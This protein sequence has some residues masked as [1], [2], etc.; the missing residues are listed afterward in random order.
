M[1]RSAI[2]STIQATG[3]AWHACAQAVCNLVASVTVDMHEINASLS[4][5][6]ANA[7]KSE[8]SFTND[9]A[10]AEQGVQLKRNW[11]K[12][13]SL[14]GVMAAVAT[15]M[16]RHPSPSYALASEPIGQQVTLLLSF[17][18]HMPVNTSAG[19]CKVTPCS[20]SKGQA[21][22]AILCIYYIVAASRA[23]GNSSNVHT[24]RCCVAGVAPEGGTA[25]CCREC[26]GRSMH[27]CMW[28]GSRVDSSI[29]A[30]L[31]ATGATRTRFEHRSSEGACSICRRFQNI[32]CRG[33]EPGSCSG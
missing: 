31:L 13:L 20:H 9:A 10:A 7:R 12:F 15:V 17:L 19:L 14:S 22:A 2:H 24:A 29:C 28:I 33:I 30:R 8:A 11:A 23:P 18:H 1:C 27:S 21:S 4:D 3:T 32:N 6:H 5:A 16:H 25:T 26:S